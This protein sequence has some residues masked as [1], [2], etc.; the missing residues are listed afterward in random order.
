[1]IVTQRMPNTELYFQ[2]RRSEIYP[3]P[4]NDGTSSVEPPVLSNRDK[5]LEEPIDDITKHNADRHKMNRF[6]PPMDAFQVAKANVISE[7]ASIVAPCY[8]MTYDQ[9]VDSSLLPIDWTTSPGLEFKG[10]T[11]KQLIDDPAFKERVMKLYKSFAGGNSA[12]PQV[13]YTTYLKD[14]VRSKEKVKKGATRTITA[15]SFDYTIACRMIFGN[16]FRQLF[17]NGLPAG[18]APGMNPYT[19]FDELYDSCRLNVICLDYSKF[20]ASLSKEL[21]EHA[22]EVV[23]CF[24]ED[25]MSVIRAFQPTLISQERV[26]DELW[27]VR[28]SMPSGS[29]W[30]TMINTICNLLMCKTYLLDMGHDITKTYVVCYG[31]DC[32]ISV[33]QC[34]R[35]EGIEQWFMDKFGATVTPED[36]SGKIKWRFKNK[37][38]FLKRTPMQ[39]DWL[40]KIVGALDIDSMMDRIQWTK[41]HFQE[42]L[43]CFYYELA[44]HGE[45]TYNEARRSIAFRCPELVHPTYHCALETIKPMVSLM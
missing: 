28:G 33:D 19:Q 37:L 27:E 40:P 6:N 29:P 1:G 42:Q 22:I 15:S 20:D 44:L 5:R 39:L 10:K 18:F 24:S 45:D 4:A 7:L 25:P 36:K 17:G 41:G 11:K 2:P 9:V 26:S 43:N 12:P 8:H 38:K 23:A 16:I 3:S 13:K 14:E 34:H 21:M 31:D 30:T 32:V 35:L